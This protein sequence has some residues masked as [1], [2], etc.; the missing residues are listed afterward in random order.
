[1]HNQKNVQAQKNSSNTHRLPAAHGEDGNRSTVRHDNYF[2]VTV[3]PYLGSEED[4]MTARSFVTPENC[5]QHVRP[6][7]TV[8]GEHQRL[9]CLTSQ[10]HHCTIFKKESAV[11]LKPKRTLHYQKASYLVP[12]FLICL[13]ILFTAVIL[14]S[15]TW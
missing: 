2:P 12:T 7:T 8:K 3:C 4:P 6:A 5:C 13:I 10:Y 15:L 9:Y 11:K 14:A 1:M